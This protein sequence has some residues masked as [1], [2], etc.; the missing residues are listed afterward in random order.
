MTIKRFHTPKGLTEWLRA[1][2]DANI[3]EGDSQ[4]DATTKLLT[5]IRDDIAKLFFDSR[6]V[7]DSSEVVQMVGLFDHDGYDH[8]IIRLRFGDT[9]R[10]QFSGTRNGWIVSCYLPVKVTV[11]FDRLFDPDRQADTHQFRASGFND[12][13]IYG[14]YSDDPQKFTVILSASRYE[15]YYFMR[16]ISELLHEAAVSREAPDAA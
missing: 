5:F 1:Y 2:L 16:R 14:P 10:I 7:Y 11:K 13:E 15:L 6:T 8:P 4:G 12:N 3:M 9:W